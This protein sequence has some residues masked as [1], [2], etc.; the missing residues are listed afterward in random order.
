MIANLAL[1]TLAQLT[2]A[3]AAAVA[4]GPQSARKATAGLLVAAGLALPWLAPPVPLFRAGVTLLALTVLI[5][6]T[7]LLATPGPWTLRRRLWNVIAPFDVVRARPVTPGLDRRVLLATVLHTVLLAL[8]VLALLR[9]RTHT[10]FAHDVLRVL[11]GAVFVY[12]LVDVAAGAVTLVH[13][14][15]GVAVPVIQDHPVLSRSVAE[16]WGERWSHEMGDW[17]RRLVFRPLRR[18]HPRLALLATFGV[19]AAIHAWLFLVPLGSGAAISV[20]LFFVVQGVVVLAEQPL[21][22]SRWP[23]APAR[24]WTVGVLV[25]SSPLFTDPMLRGLGL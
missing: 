9:L 1:W 6:T 8:A 17:L 2:F 19:S 12:T 13:R 25:G 16:F 7:L 4:V 21:R 18:R 24:A 14:L 3:V 10:G 20:A 11:G 23:E 5:K 15:A 22:V